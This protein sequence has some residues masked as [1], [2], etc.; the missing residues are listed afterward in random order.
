MAQNDG[1]QE[2]V[3]CDNLV[4]DVDDVVACKMGQSPVIEIKHRW[5]L[6]KQREKENFLSDPRWKNKIRSFLE[7]L[8]S[9]P[10][11]M[12]PFN[13][14]RRSACVCMSGTLTEKM[15]VSVVD[16]IFK[17]ALLDYQSTQFADI[18]NNQF[19]I[20]IYTAHKFSLI[21]IKYY[22]IIFL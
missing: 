11:C 10:F 6:L 4:F 18:I 7:E 1:I 3:I 5:R 9:R 21:L 20:K 12:D 19:S 15:K 22:N 13:P 8:G 14:Q 16:E 2:P 17:F